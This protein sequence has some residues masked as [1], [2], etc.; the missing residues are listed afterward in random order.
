MVRRPPVLV[1]QAPAGGVLELTDP[2]FVSDVHL[3]AA[4]P[5]T[6]ARFLRFVRQDA[7]RHAEL[8][9]LGDLFEY[10]VG[11]DL[12]AEA[13][14]TIAALRT[15]ADGGTR[16]FLM[17]GNRDLLLGA[18]FATAAGATLLPDPT[19]AR[20]GGHSVLLAHGDAFCTDDAGYMRFRRFARG[21]LAQ[22]GFL[23]LPAALR[24]ALVRRARA[25]SEDS[26]RGKPPAIMDVAPV[27][28]AAALRAADAAL[29][30]HGHTHRPAVHRLD[31]D[32]RRC[33]RWVLPDWD[34]DG[35]ERGGYI[36]FDR[37]RPYAAAI[38]G[39]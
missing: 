33:E 10:W 25:A 17:H 8:L 30:I 35:A 26:K 2:V 15:L 18:A 37:G 38:A 4:Q 32:G 7:V 28:V 29:L 6:R 34:F 12:S 22:R 14:D 1:P 31:I 36:A 27:A 39:R 24:W 13:A 23:S 20:V 9:I 11:D 19:L 5:R 3:S 21:V 16:L